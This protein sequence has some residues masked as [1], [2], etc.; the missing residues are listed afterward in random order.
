MRVLP[1]DTKYELPTPALIKLQLHLKIYTL[2]MFHLT[3]L[4]FSIILVQNT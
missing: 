1:N 4:K 3:T 2:T